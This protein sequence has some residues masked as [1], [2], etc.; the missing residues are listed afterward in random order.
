METQEALNVLAQVVENYFT[1][2]PKD[3][4]VVQQ[5]LQTIKDATTPP[6]DADTTDEED[7]N[8]K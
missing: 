1:G 5:A 6:V 8:K 2:L 7:G 3:Q 4:R